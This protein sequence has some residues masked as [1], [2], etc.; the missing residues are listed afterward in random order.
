MLTSGSGLVH[1]RSILY[2]MLPYILISFYILF[3]CIIAHLYFSIYIFTSLAWFNF[4]Y[5]AALKLMI[6]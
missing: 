3:I 5:D 2:F 1:L 6:M 4:S